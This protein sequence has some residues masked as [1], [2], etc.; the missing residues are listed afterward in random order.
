V[1]VAQ[2]ANGIPISLEDRWLVVGTTGSGKTTFARELLARLARLY[3]QV[4]IYVLDSKAVGDFRMWYRLADVRTDEDVPPPLKAGIQIWQPGVDNQDAYDA[5]FEQLLKTRGPCMTLVDEISSI[6]K[7]KGNDAPPGFQ[8]LLKQGRA[9]GKLTINCTQEM[10]YVPRQ[11]KTQTTHVVRFRLTG[12]HDPVVA[13]RLMGRGNHDAEPRAKYG[14]FYSRIDKP[15]SLAEYPG[16]K[17]F[18]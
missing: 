6:G 1:P 15:G 13:N 5:W 18:F 11:I 4:P 3:P 7:G 10:A 12:D 17:E 16:F 14:F 9:A 8:R 2:R